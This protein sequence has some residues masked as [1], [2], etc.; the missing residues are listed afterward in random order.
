[1]R[2]REVAP[3]IYGLGSGQVNWYLVEEGGRLSAIDAGLPGFAKTLADDLAKLGVALADIDAVVLTHSDGD[4][5][6]VAPLL[7]DA[8]A[9]VLIHSGDDATL[10]KPGPKGG[11]AKAVNILKNLWRPATLKVLGH[12]LRYGGA[13]PPKI[14]GAETFAHDDVLDVPGRLRVIHTPGHTPGHCALLAQSHRV[15]LAGDALIDHPIVTQGR[16]PQI[17]PTFT[18]VDNEQALASL[19]ALAAVDEEADLVLFGHGEPWR[20]GARAAVASARAQRA[21]ATA[22]ASSADTSS[23]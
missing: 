14:E 17:M 23:R 11:D 20:D 10:R 4:H 16:G 18:N 8:G 6:G 3:G 15:L 5:T 2:P 13:K 7:R 22:S 1:M 12:M 21:A 9:R 19:D